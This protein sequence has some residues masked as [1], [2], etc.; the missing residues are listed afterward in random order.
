ML[1]DVTILSQ[2][3]WL[4]MPQDYQFEHMYLGGDI[5]ARR[6]K[7]E[8]KHKEVMSD[9]HKEESVTEGE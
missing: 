3:S 4:K 5:N 7:G 9:Q 2:I 6:E 8:K 1:S